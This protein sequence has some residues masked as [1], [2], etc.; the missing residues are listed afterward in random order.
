MMSSILFSAAL[1]AAQLASGQDQAAPAAPASA[2]A[3]TISVG[4]KVQGPDGSVVGTVVQS[5][6][7]VVVIDTG[8]AKAAFA[9][10][11]FTRSGD[12]LL[13]GLSKVQVE[14]AAVQAVKDAQAKMSALLVKGTAVVDTA[15]VPVGTVE[16][17]DADGLVVSTGKARAKIPTTAFASNGSQLILGMTRAQLEAAA[18]GAR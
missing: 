10:G 9:P 6:A 11:S 14:Q 15:G 3:G 7:G 18:G 8:T 17:V 12:V 1:A 16:S 5:D 13:F 4:T 2:A